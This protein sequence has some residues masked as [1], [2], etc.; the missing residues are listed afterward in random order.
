[1]AP[2]LTEPMIL[3]TIKSELYSRGDVIVFKGENQDKTV[4]HRIVRV[5][6]TGYITRGDNNLRDDKPVAH[7][8]V[9]GK[10]IMA[11][12]GEKCYP[13]RNGI[14]GSRRHK[15]LQ[16]RK[17]VMGRLSRFLS[18]P[19]HFISDSGFFKILL[20]KNLKPKV[21]LYQDK[22]GHLYLGNILIGRYDARRKKWVIFRPW[23]IFIDQAKLPDEVR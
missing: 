16:L 15:Y 2:T 23:K 9:L 11:F 7:P 3:E 17:K 20:P 4:V 21:I 8:D 1:M 6:S 12:R 5:S 18:M 14:W 10:A 19:Y 22:P 13:I